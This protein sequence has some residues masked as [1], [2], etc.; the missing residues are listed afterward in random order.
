MLNETFSVI[1]KHRVVD[2]IYRV[3]M[4]DLP[5]VAKNTRELKLFTGTSCCEMGRKVGGMAKKAAISWLL[6]TI[7]E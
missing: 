5:I 3:P 1:F 4:Y 7:G 6:L 2:V